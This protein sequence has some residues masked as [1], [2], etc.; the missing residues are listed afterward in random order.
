M[1]FCLLIKK[2]NNK[3][4]GTA[5]GK[6]ISIFSKTLFEKPDQKIGISWFIQVSIAALVTSML[7]T[8]GSTE[9]IAKVG[10]SEV[11]VDGSKH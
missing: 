7:M 4:I 1:S 11:K 9:S 6:F 3:A 10:E 5:V 2:V 8:T